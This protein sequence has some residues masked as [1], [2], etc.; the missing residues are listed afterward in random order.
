M[1]ALVVAVCGID[2]GGDRWFGRY[3]SEWMNA[4]PDRS[5]WAERFERMAAEMLDQG[6]DVVTLAESAARSWL[7]YRSPAALFR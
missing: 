5:V 2:F 3:E 6:F 1:G 7:P 4:D